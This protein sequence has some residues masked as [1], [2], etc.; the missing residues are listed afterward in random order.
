[1]GRINCD[2]G[3]L[4]Q[5][6]A[7][8]EA[9]QMTKLLPLMADIRARYAGDMEGMMKALRAARGPAHPKVHAT[10]ADVVKH[11]NHVVHVAGIDHVGLGS[12][13][14]GVQCVPE[15]TEQRG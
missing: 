6:A 12:D 9:A 1:L 11:L 10:L 14:D 5:E 7:T 15:G 2:C 3:Y 4:N 8:A 13:F